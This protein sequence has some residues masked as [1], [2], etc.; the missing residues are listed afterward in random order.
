MIDIISPAT[1]STTEEIVLMQQFLLQKKIQ[2]NFFDLNLVSIKEK[3]QHS[4]STV[5]PQVRF[6]QFQKACLNKESQ[7]IW[8]G[9]GGYGSSEL[10]PFLAKM[11]QPKQKKLLIGYS[12]ITN[13]ANFIIKNW[14]WPVLMAPMLNCI[15]QQ[16]VSPISIEKIFS[17][18]A[19]KK[20]KT[21]YNIKH[22]AGKSKKNIIN[23]KLIGGCLS[24]LS[25]SFATSYQLDF[26]QKI[27]L[28]E[29][30]GEEGEKIDRY[31]TQLL[32]IF[33]NTKY[34]PKAIILGN[35]K[36]NFHQEQI[37]KIDFA[38]N[39]F[40]C[41]LQK[42]QPNILLLQETKNILGHSYE[43][44]PIFLGKKVIINLEKSLLSQN[45]YYETSL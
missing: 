40:A 4:F 27:I 38:I 23:G 13:I 15:I 2:S 37:N 11:P 12:D 28:L 14:Q 10:L 16:K 30:I 34:L 39:N 36:Q 21:K 45:F 31:F 24:V 35:F 17:F 19:T 18:L 1:P 22:L 43:M 20:N 6:S 3:N 42:S 8:C 5:S 9:R 7:I 41:N 33:N 44:S 32:Q 26:Y 25:A 29:D